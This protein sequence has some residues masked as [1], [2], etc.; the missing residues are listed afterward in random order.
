M[1][2]RVATVKHTHHMP[3]W[4]V[5]LQRR[6]RVFEL[7]GGALLFLAVLS[8][9]G[10]L[11][12]PQDRALPLMHMGGHD[13]GGKS[14]AELVA[15]FENYAQEGEVTVSSPSREW[16]AKWQSIGLSIDAEASADAAVSYQQ[17]ERFIPFSGLIKVRQTGDLPLVALVDTER[18]NEFATKLVAEDKLAARDATIS[19]K[20]GKVVVDEAKNGYA[21]RAE[22][23]TQQ[24]QATTVTADAKIRLIPEPT[25]FVRSN[26]EISQVK[27]QA[28]QMLAHT[29]TLKAGNESFTPQAATIGEWLV[30]SEDPKTKALTL[31]FDPEPMRAYL[32]QLDEKT[33]IAPGT[34][35]VTLLD[36][37]E[38]SRT[39]APA[40]K[41]F[42]TD[43]SIV[44]IQTALQAKPL[45]QVVALKAVNTRPKE[46]FVRT[47]S[48]SSEG[49]LAIIKDWDTHFYGDYAVIVRELGG[50]NRYAE[51]L[52]D[53]PY[54]TASTFKLWVYYAVQDKIQKGELSYQ[55]RTDIGWSVEACL[56][57]M[58]VRSTNPCAI[59]LLNLVGWQE[60]QRLVAAA[61]FSSTN[62][63]NQGGGDK[64][65]TIRDETNFM[66]RLHYGTLMGPEATDRLLGY[67]KRQ[68]WR[69]GIPSGVPRGT[70]VA[71]KVG[72]YDGWVHDVGIIY[73][74]KS[75]FIVGI[76]SKSGS[77]PAFADLARRMYAFFLN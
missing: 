40:G 19:I 6:R 37:Q 54:V 66:M 61:G 55:T 12:Y 74:P 47:Y 24:I 67:L 58:I 31:A 5:W 39:P 11:W 51:Y 41:T 76:M 27:S 15:M 70:V 59:S 20:D 77:D 14:R 7:I 43:A 38:I 42:A 9:V 65:S 29:L 25:A 2:T 4:E 26:Q 17:W 8:V 63:N 36:G 71:D 21:F 69:A 48:Q 53:K 60:A 33:K 13:I 68:V 34:S 22:D 3:G 16:R 75:T 62:I 52:P 18:L 64:W 28:E 23:I 50:Q 10:Q 49:L 56:Q 73:G 72:L 1:T 35:T 57:E 46:T 44:A 30:F 32:Q 45:N